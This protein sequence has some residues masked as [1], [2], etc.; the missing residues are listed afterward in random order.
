VQNQNCQREVTYK[1]T[2]SRFACAVEVRLF[3][4]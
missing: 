2:G 3:A 4:P 1:E